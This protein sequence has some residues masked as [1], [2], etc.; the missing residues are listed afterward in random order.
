MQAWQIIALTVYAMFVMW[1]ELGPQFF[2]AKPVV[3][4]MMAG[5]I[6]GDMN[7]GLFI[8]GTLQLMVLGV[9]TYGG[10][11][12]PDYMSGA[13]IGTAFAVTSMRGGMDA[14]GAQTVGLTVAVP[15]G[16]LLV[17]CDILGR[18]CN[19]VF[20]NMA[21]AGAKEKNWSK[22]E[23]GCLLGAIPWCLSRG[24]PVL[25]CLSLGQGP[26]QAMATAAPEWLLNGF[27]LVSGML[28]AVGIAI[29]LRF[30]PL[31]R[32]WPY[33]LLGFVLAAYLKVPMLGIA[34]VGLVFAA[35]KYAEF[36]QKPVAAVAAAS[37][38]EGGT[39]DDDE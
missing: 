37:T 34:L 12:I 23:L 4:G 15:V 7:T 14:A 3:A 24:I 26:V 10:S 17:Q 1:E 33:A 35:V 22:V 8:G 21:D 6:M 5:L 9:G 18:F 28:P 13:L 38:T 32:F 36:T 11:S 31:N 25:L 20:Q 29:L 19:T 39:I 27:K 16:L 30:M 2:L